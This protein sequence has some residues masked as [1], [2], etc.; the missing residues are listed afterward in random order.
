M[1]LD[2]KDS[3]VDKEENGEK[4]V[5]SKPSVEDL[6]KNEVTELQTEN[7]RLHEIITQLHQRHHETTLKVSVKYCQKIPHYKV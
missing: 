4:E 3:D 2:K 7:K 5:S 6:L 1:I